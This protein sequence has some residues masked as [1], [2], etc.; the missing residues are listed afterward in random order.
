[1]ENAA[2]II[3]VKNKYSRIVTNYLQSKKLTFRVF[4]SE[5]QP[6]T[7]FEIQNITPFDA[8]HLGVFS[9]VQLSDGEFLI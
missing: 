4:Q 5:D 7:K 3:E 8:F 6:K 9:Q 2:T 1:M